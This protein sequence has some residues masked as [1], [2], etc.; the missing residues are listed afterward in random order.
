M[1]FRAGVGAGE[2]VVTVYPLPEGMSATGDGG[3]VDGGRADGS[4]AGRSV[5]AGAST[6]G[7]VPFYSALPAP[8]VGQRGQTVFSRLKA[9]LRGVPLA[10]L[11]GVLKRRAVRVLRDGESVPEGKGFPGERVKAGSV[12]GPRDRVLVP[13]EFLEEHGWASEEGRGRDTAGVLRARLEEGVAPATALKYRRALGGGTAAARVARAEPPPLLGEYVRG[14]VLGGRDSS[15]LVLN[16]PHGLATQPGTD[17]AWSLHDLA[18]ALAQGVG[19]KV[20]GGGAEAPRLVHRL[21]RGASGVLLMARSA[22]VA[23]EIAAF[24]KDKS[25]AAGVDAGQTSL[26]VVKE[27]TKIATLGGVERTYWALVE[28][29]PGAREGT[30]EVQ[31]V[32]TKADKQARRR[33]AGRDAKRGVFH[34]TASQGERREDV[35]GWS[36]TVEQTIWTPGTAGVGLYSFTRF[37]VVMS[38]WIQGLGTVSWLAL[39]PA[40]GRKHQLR[41]H[42]AHVLGTPILGDVKYGSKQRIPIDDLGGRGEFFTNES[43]ELEPWQR[44]LRAA[45][46]KVLGGGGVICL[47]SRRLWMPHPQSGDVFEVAAPLSPE[48]AR[49]FAQLKFPTSAVDGT[50]WE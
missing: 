21:D 35:D 33:R 12:I 2:E 20:A 13:H 48:M 18:P 43:R 3:G 27:R 17:V 10:S 24:F 44:R 6:G 40:T 23:A 5:S 39:R 31:L 42:C 19:R 9:Q 15:L 4:R 41:I 47:H 49:L 25:L 16:K 50:E 45:K 22:E 26:S 14:L 29:H 36:K 7:L 11:N 32:D 8:A 46:R 30:V 37:Q 1:S 34:P 38:G 28:G